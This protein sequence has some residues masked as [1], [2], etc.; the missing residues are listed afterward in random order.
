VA[1]ATHSL[2]QLKIDARNNGWPWPIDHPND[3]RA[4]L[5]G[6]MPDIKRAERVRKFY[7]TAM[8]LP[9]PGGGTQPFEMLE[10]WYRD[11]MAPLFGW[12]RPDGRRRYD[13]GFITTAKKSAKSTIVSGLPLY[14]MLADGEDE[15]EAYSAATD[16]DQASI[17]FQKTLRSVRL[18]DAL[19]RVVH[20]IESRKRIEH[21]ASGSWYEAISSDADSAEG[22][23]PHLLLVDE[24]HAWKDRKFFNSLM[25]GD[26]AREQSLFL[27]I[28]TA[29]EERASVG[30]EEYELAKALFDPDDDFYSLNH[31]AF[32]AESTDE[33]EW[34][35]PQG[36]KDA[37]PSIG[38]GYRLPTI[39]K[40]QTRCDEAKKSPRKKREF[41]RYICNRWGDA[42]VNPWLDLEAWKACIALE[43]VP[44]LGERTW[45]GLDLSRTRDLTAMVLV[46]PDGECLDVECRFWCPEGRLK[47]FEE[48][49]RVPLRD[50]AQMGFVMPTPGNSV[51]YAYVR[52]E[53][54][55]V[56]LDE[57][58]KPLEGRWDGCLAER[59]DIQEIAFD[60]Y[61]ASKLVTELGEYDGLTMVEMRQGYVTLNSPSKAL[62]NLVVNR[63]LRP[64]H[65]PVLN[66]M[67]RH[68]EVD[69]DPAGNIKPSKRRSRY[70]I[71]GIVALIMA[72][73]RADLAPVQGPS[74][75]ETH[76]D[77]F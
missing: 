49:W 19:K 12:L 14:M 23:N 62:E 71:D 53:I 55:G 68:C 8:R 15:A 6:C 30:F 65:N 42:E 27:M 57:E 72:L 36:W 20:P 61:N 60:P 13:K 25:Y 46:W 28:T 70:K 39:E 26:I 17:V 58:G 54:S 21:K 63:Q 48:E 11:V 32:I 51:D 4:L 67:V 29:G 35:D 59:Y 73:G 44:H 41:L 69:D 40:L 66:W 37:N 2:A 38:Q 74:Y 56:M 47:Q 34:D 10:W 16:R 52:R 5:D 75:Y 22:K 43:Q 18:S 45:G 33:Q 24:L 50:W 77:F 9:A 1:T 7:K 64:G 3:E 31:F 76:D